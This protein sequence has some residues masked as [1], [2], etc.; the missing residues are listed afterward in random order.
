MRTGCPHPPCFVRDGVCRVLPSSMAI[1]GTASRWMDAKP[2]IRA[3]LRLPT[4]DLF[5]QLM[6]QGSAPLERTCAVAPCSRMFQHLGRYN[7]RSKIC[8][9]RLGSCE[10]LLLLPL[11]FRTRLAKNNLSSLVPVPWAYCDFLDKFL[12]DRL[13]FR[14]FALFH[15]VHC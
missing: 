5:L 3:R 13:F 11:V 9:C 1:K 6:E 8:S 4:N 12:V 2:V 15:T 7:P 10:E 14:V